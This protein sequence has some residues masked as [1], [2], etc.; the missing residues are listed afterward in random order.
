MVLGVV[1]VASCST[2]MVWLPASKTNT[3]LTRHR[4]RF[5]VEGEHN[6]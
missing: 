6:L 2:V 5:V 3:F 1:L 4:A